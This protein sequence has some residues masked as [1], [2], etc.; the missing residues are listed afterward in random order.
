MNRITAKR[1]EARLTFINK[2]LGRPLSPWDGATS[3]S[4]P[5]HL[6]LEA[7]DYG[8]TVLEIANESGGVSTM[9][10]SMPAGQLFRL[11]G[12]FLDGIKARKGVNEEY[13]TGCGF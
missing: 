6:Y 7:N 4:N 10:P 2:V 12:A 1:L 11:L 3:K 9:Y 13:A 8:Y 5:G